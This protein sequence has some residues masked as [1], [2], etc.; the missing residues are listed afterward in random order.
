MSIHTK[1]LPYGPVP[2]EILRSLQI[3]AQTTPKYL[4]TS[5]KDNFCLYITTSKIPGLSDGAMYRKKTFIDMIFLY[6]IN[7]IDE[8]Y[9]VI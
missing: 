3:I 7:Y 6:I 1:P 2:M 4:Y 9:I 5:A 8:Y